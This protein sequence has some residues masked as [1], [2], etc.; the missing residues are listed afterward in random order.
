MKTISVTKGNKDV[1]LFVLENIPTKQINTIKDLRIIDK[2]CA[3]IEESTDTLVLED[4]DFDYLKRKAEN[5]DQ[6]NPAKE[7]R[8]LVLDS[9]GKLNE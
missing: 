8:K 7:A 9:I 4:T 2:L 5:F 3:L 1:F 6:W